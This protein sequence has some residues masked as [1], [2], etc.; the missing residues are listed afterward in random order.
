MDKLIVRPLKEAA[1]STVIV[2]DALDECEDDEYASVILSVLGQFVSQIPKV[3]FFI[4]GRLDSWIQRGFRLPLLAKAT[5]VT[6]LSPNSTIASLI[7]G[8][9]GAGPSVMSRSGG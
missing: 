2:I 3:K 9:D 7:P 8:G 5:E 6:E 1:I 4:T